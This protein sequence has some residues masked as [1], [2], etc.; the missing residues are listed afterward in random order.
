MESSWVFYSKLYFIALSR[1]KYVNF[2]NM[3][4]GSYSYSYS[5]FYI[6]KILWMKN[7]NFINYS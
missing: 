4:Y 7:V 5:Y 3:T 2:S 1:R 6:Q